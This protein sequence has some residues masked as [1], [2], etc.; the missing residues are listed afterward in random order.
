LQSGIATNPSNLVDGVFG[1]QP[2]T[3]SISDGIGATAQITVASNTISENSCS[4]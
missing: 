2:L 3:S 1:N 4:K